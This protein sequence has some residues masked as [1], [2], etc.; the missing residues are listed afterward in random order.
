MSMPKSYPP[1]RM[2]PGQV[3]P[4]FVHS[5]FSKFQNALRVYHSTTDTYPVSLDSLFENER[6][7]NI[8]FMHTGPAGDRPSLRRAILIDPW[9]NAYLYTLINRKIVLRSSGPDGSTN[10]E[11]DIVFEKEI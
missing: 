11:D 8:M 7:R 1:H 3:K 4:L 6:S 9:G 10:T 2:P 5:A